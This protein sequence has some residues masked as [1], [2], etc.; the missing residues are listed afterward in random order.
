MTMVRTGEANRSQLGLPGD[1][2]GTVG[3]RLLGTISI[4]KASK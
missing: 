1:S 3:R 4:V 2:C